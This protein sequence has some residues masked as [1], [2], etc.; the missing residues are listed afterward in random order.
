MDAK[1]RG[2]H[3]FERGQVVV[4]TKDWVV[5]SKGYP[6]TGAVGIVL[7]QTRPECVEVVFPTV[8]GENI[9]YTY[10]LNDPLVLLFGKHV[11]GCLPENLKV[12]E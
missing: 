10:Q 7:E 3:M 2:L 9:G 4:R 1:Q 8:K 5:K 6:N 12:V 11:F